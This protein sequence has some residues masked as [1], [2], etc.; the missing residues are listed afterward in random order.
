MTSSP[1]WHQQ[2]TLSYQKYV[3]TIG[4]ATVIVLFAIFRYFL[5]AERELNAR[6]STECLRA[7]NTMSKAVDAMREENSKLRGRIEQ[8]NRAIEENRAEEKGSCLQ[9]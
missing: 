7:V 4:L 1:R 8:L 2:E 5:K 3:L 9:M 6:R